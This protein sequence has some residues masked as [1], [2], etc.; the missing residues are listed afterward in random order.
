MKNIPVFAA[1]GNHDTIT[2][3]TETGFQNNLGLLSFIYNW[4]NHNWLGGGPTSSDANRRGGGNYFFVYGNALYISLNTNVTDN[5][6]HRNFI[7]QAVAA[8]PNTTWRIVQFHQDI[9]GNG[10]GHA[11]TMP[12][13]RQALGQ[14]L[15]DNKIDIVFNGHDHTGSRSHFMR[16]TTN[17]LRQ[18][19][20]D[21]SRNLNGQLIFDAHPG[22]FVAPEGIPYIALGSVSDFPKYTSVLP[23]MS[24]TAWTD[25]PEHDDYAQ[26]SLM[27]IDGDSLTVQTF[28]IPY[29]PTNWM[30]P[31]G[32]EF[33]TQSFTIRKTARFED[34]KKLRDDAKNFLR[35]NFTAPTWIAFQK[36]IADADALDANS[37]AA[38]I[39]AAYM[40]IYDRFFALQTGMCAA[41]EKNPCECAMPC[42]ICWTTPCECGTICEACEKISCECEP[43]C[44]KCEKISC[45]CEPVCEKC[46]KI[47]CE[48][49][50]EKCKIF[51]SSTNVKKG[52]EILV[53][54]SI[55][56][57]PGFNRLS[58][59][60]KFPSEFTLIKQP[61]LVDANLADGFETTFYEEFSILHF[62]WA[63]AN[64]Y[65]D[66]G[67]LVTLTFAADSE[68][69][70]GLYDIEFSE[71]I[72]NSAFPPGVIAANAAGEEVE[73][74][75]VA[76]DVLLRDIAPEL[77]GIVRSGQTEL[78]L[79]D[80]TLILRYLAG[81]DLR[82]SPFV[83]DRYAGIVTPGSLLRGDVRLMDATLIARFLAGHDVRLGR[84]PK[85]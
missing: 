56:N 81:H 10:T 6:T 23:P 2:Q 76:G 17:V 77:L 14:I 46:E 49:V 66:D 64:D 9:F 59:E 26:Y 73:I 28:A 52:D 8:H 22:V 79:D 11:H 25:P 57:N 65:R 69:A 4:P 70:S 27:E 80:A 55:E 47:S 15:N 84:Y 13:N 3:S 39:H 85:E 63:R 45:A 71:L 83:F 7:Q 67:A 37:P 31:S 21:F 74:E 29:S 32:E 82:D 20:A 38:S 35:G 41:C 36:A 60:I 40:E 75:S 78:T 30:Q 12:G 50:R 58:F 34:L 42:E 72:V 24:W 54:V 61:E 62:Y 44:E 51:I 53:T 33:L 48:C 5:N 68:I 19:P 1:V 16:G 18:R 43:I